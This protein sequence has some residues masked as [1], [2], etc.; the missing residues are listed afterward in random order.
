MAIIMLK[1][2]PEALQLSVY[3]WHAHRYVLLVSLS[4]RAETSNLNAGLLHH[5]C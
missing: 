3:T 5:H 2:K 4:L 1:I